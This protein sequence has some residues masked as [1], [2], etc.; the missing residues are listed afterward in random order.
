MGIRLSFGLGPVRASIPLM[1]R[2]RVRT[3]Y[4]PRAAKVYDHYAG[5]RRHYDMAT[6]L[7]RAGL[8][9]AEEFATVTGRLLAGAPPGRR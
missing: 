3:R 4:V 6:E 7:C 2:R 8:L 1:S 5:P 9:T